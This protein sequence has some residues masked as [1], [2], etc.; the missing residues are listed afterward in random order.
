MTCPD[1][2]WSQRCFY[3]HFSIFLSFGI[4]PKVPRMAHVFHGPEID[5]LGTLKLNRHGIPFVTSKSLPRPQLHSLPAIQCLRKGESVSQGGSPR[6][7]EQWVLSCMCVL[8]LS[9][10]TPINCSFSEI[11]KRA[12]VNIFLAFSHFQIF[13][14]D[15]FLVEFFLHKS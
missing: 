10:P 12:E 7:C 4:F 2:W 13:P 9:N 3:V 8:W 5:W 6:S 11:M 1:R 14:Q 15:K